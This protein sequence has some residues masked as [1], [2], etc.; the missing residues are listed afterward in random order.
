MRTTHA[1]LVATLGASMLPV[2]A[3]AQTIYTRPPESKVS[4]SGILGVFNI[5]N[6]FAGWFYALILAL[7]V[8]FIL[9]AAFNYLT[10]AG[11]E[12]KLKKAKGYLTYAVI[13]VAVAILATSFVGLTRALLEP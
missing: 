12:E 11:D 1:Q 9:I 13:A 8:V 10:A 3:G 5:L 2:I 7:A 6:T 4:Q